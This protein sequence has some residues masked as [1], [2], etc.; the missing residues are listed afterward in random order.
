M[1]LPIVYCDAAGLTK[2]SQN[3]NRP[4]QKSGKLEKSWA[5]H[6]SNLINSYQKCESEQ[7]AVILFS[8]YFSFVF[9]NN[10]VKALLKRILGFVVWVRQTIGKHWCGFPFGIELSWDTTGRPSANADSD[11]CGG[12]KGDKIVPMPRKQ[13]TSSLGETSTSNFQVGLLYVQFKHFFLCFFGAEWLHFPFH[14]Y[15]SVQMFI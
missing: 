6:N 7:T 1:A 9:I 2:R 11:S 4:E 12:F 13:C 15:A 8:V 10:N 3:W 5:R 14:L